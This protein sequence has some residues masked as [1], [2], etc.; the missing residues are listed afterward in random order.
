MKPALAL[1]VVLGLSCNAFAQKS[2][3]ARILDNRS[4]FGPDIGAVVRLIPALV[5]AGELRIQLFPDRIIGDRRYETAEQANRVASA[6]NEKSRD[7]PPFAAMTFIDDQ[8][9]NIASVAKEARFL[10]PRLR[11]DV[12]VRELGQPER[13][14]RLVIDSGHEFRPVILDLAVYAGGAVIFA[15]KQGTADPQ[16]INRVFLD[17]RRINA[18]LH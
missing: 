15:T 7:L 2:N 18:E 4:L 11:M 10:A 12:V 16:A 9:I 17:A 14:E 1:L 8:K 3:A 6:I 13:R 5:A